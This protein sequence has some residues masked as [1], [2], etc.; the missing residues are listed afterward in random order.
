MIYIETGEQN[1]HVRNHIFNFDFE[2]P[3]IDIL[4]FF[5]IIKVNLKEKIFKNK[6]D[7]FLRGLT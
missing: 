6:L 2:C 3:G 1:T 5:K 7:D 4:K